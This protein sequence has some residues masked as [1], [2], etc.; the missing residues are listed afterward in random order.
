MTRPSLPFRV[1]TLVVA[2]AL[3]LTWPSVFAQS[4]P[5][6]AYFLSIDCGTTTAYTDPVSGVNWVPDTNYTS[7]GTNVASVAGGTV[8]AN[9]SEAQTLRYFEEPRKKFCYELPVE[10]N[11]S[12]FI[13]ASFWYGNYDGLNKPPVF[14]M[15][16]DAT[17]LMQIDLTDSVWT[18]IIK[19]IEYV[20]RVGVEQTS[21]SVCF[22]QDT[23][24][25]TTPFVSSIELRRLDPAAYDHPWIDE[26]NF[27]WPALRLDLGGAKALRYPDDAYDRI[28]Y[29][30]PV[31]GTTTISTKETISNLNLPIKPPQALL[32]TAITPTNISNLV[33]P[34]G[35]F[36]VSSAPCM[37]I[38]FFAEIS[39][40]A[41]ATS[42][43]FTVSIPNDKP[44]DDTPVNIYTMAGGVN[45]ALVQYWSNMTLTDT[46]AVILKLTDPPTLDG[47]LVNGAELLWKYPEL[48]QPTYA[49]DAAALETIKATLSL[50]SWSGDPCLPVPYDWITCTV[51]TSPRVLTV[52][53][54]GYN[55][56][57]LIPDAFA[58]LTS[59]T[60]LDLSNN[61]LSGSI[62][63]SLATLPELIEL[64]LTNNNLS[65]TIPTTLQRPK[66]TLDIRGNPVCNCSVKVIPPSSPTT[67]MSSKNKSSNIGVIA[68]V[69]GGIL[70]VVLGGAFLLVFYCIRRH[71]KA[72]ANKLMELPS[73]QGNNGNVEKNN[74]EHV[75][76]ANGN[77][78]GAKAYSFAELT[79][80]TQ[81]FSK[82]IGEG[83]F[84]PVY[85]GKVGGQEVVVKV[86][87]ANSQ[88]GVNEFNNEVQLLS[89]VHHKNLVSL[90]GYC[91]ENKN[92]MLVY[93]FLHK[94]TI[95]EHLYGSPLAH[96]EPLDWK[97]R[98][99]IALNSAQGLE[100]LHS[101]CTPSIIHRDVK[102]SNILLTNK[103]VAKVADFGLSKLGPKDGQAS[104]VSTMVKGTTGYLD[105]EYWSTN[106]L[107]NK[108]DVYSFGVV[109]LELL[110]GNQPIDNNLEDKSK[111]HIS[112]KV[113]NCLHTS[114]IESILDPVVKSCHPNMNSV[115]KVAEVAIQSVEPKGMHRP[116]M[117]DVV[118]E[119][120]EAIVLETGH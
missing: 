93:E 52:N 45:K 84:G 10:A 7:V 50:T 76:M 25:M 98:L 18:T 117:R 12:Y 49:D 51:V 63:N 69:V 4:G 118:Q 119:L 64:I 1:L 111:Q 26:G 108:S 42:R 120:R 106:N 112:E 32:Q 11:Q 61:N 110:C 3:T 9:N 28:W 102:S 54:T 70:G 91:L 71:N 96:K 39:A 77:M 104:H 94:G 43:A 62:P 6:Q 47:P 24:S 78:Q 85:Y 8:T 46:A 109:L 27:L 19:R 48:T 81:N 16:I 95:R 89:R 53:L 101:G 44:L 86:L 97:M 83:G 21:M 56:S 80:A 37:Y 23:T 107:T 58:K 17:T 88:Q 55:L 68:S 5:S 66:L 113:R 103:Y 29:P 15:A 74:G 31:D 14:N 41:T 22:Y 100:Y 82:K 40:N 75:A 57:G 87:D 114:N 67:P 79:F 2:A 65:G 72:K 73:H 92:Q 36:G 20:R 13:A 38:L 33:I 90:V 60:S 35:P 59:L 30:W 116:F 34:Y 115:W 105:P 99:D